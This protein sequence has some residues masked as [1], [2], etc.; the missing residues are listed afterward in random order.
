MA[1]RGHQGVSGYRWQWTERNLLGQSKDWSAWAGGA[2]G[3]LAVPTMGF[4]PPPQ[5]RG[6]LV[7]LYEFLPGWVSFHREWSLDVHC[8]PLVL[9]HAIAQGHLHWEQQDD[10]G[11]VAVLP[12]YSC[13]CPLSQGHWLGPPGDEAH[14]G[15]YDHKG[16][17]AR[18]SP[19]R[20]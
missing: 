10:A 20:A 2:M 12:G 7:T 15:A 16:D 3:P 5:P 9:K 6:Y 1:E 17:R 19:Q 13:C 14:G 8:V 11:E 4:L 18:V